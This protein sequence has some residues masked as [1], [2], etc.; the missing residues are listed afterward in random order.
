[1]Y[2][3]EFSVVSSRNGDSREKSV[4]ND[5]ELMVTHVLDCYLN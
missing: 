5:T 2:F 1:M 3:Y 4:E